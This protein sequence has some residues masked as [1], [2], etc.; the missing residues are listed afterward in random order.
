MALFEKFSDDLLVC[1]YNEAHK[2]AKRQYQIHIARC[3]KIH[4]K[5]Q[6][7]E[8]PFN[9]G[10]RV[11]KA[12][13]TAHLAAC[14]NNV[15]LLRD[16]VAN[17]KQSEVAA[18]SLVSIAQPMAKEVMPSED[19]D[20]WETNEVED[21]KPL[22]T[23]ILRGLEEVPTLLMAMYDE[24]HLR[25][26]INPQLLESLSQNERD[27]LYEAR[28]KAIGKTSAPNADIVPQ[29]MATAPSQAADEE[30]GCG[31]IKPAVESQ[32]IRSV[33]AADW[34]KAYTFPPQRIFVPAPA[35]EQSVD[36]TTR[37]PATKMRTTMT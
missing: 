13:L 7:V 6:L 12:D 10:H 37:M 32:I 17:T 21:V 1:P 19:A 25:A 30:Y 23:F 8:C 20:P 11:R 15:Q 5:Q 3:A 22:G 33:N 2:V 18:R 26:P 36:A 27:Q 16:I 29:I 14:P 35:A 4:A 9:V 34:G 24:Q 31:R 28:A